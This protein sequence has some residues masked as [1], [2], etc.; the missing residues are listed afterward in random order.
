MLISVFSCFFSIAQ[1][2]PNKS[3][4]SFS[5]PRSEIPKVFIVF[6]VFIVFQHRASEKNYY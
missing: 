2:A 3:F 5:A 4:Y 1:S 6:C